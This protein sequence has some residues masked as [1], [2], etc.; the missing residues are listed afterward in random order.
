MFAICDLCKKHI[1]ISEPANIHIGHLCPECLAKIKTLNAS[2]NLHGSY[3]DDALN[4]SNFDFIDAFSKDESDYIDIYDYET[5]SSTTTD[6]PFTSEILNPHQIK[7]ELDKH[8]I[9]QERAKKVIA[10]GIYN[11]YKRISTQNSTIQKSNI[12]LVGP[13]GC[14]KTELARSVAKILNVPFAIADAT[15]VTEAGYVGD[16]VENILR[17]LISA[18]DNDVKK[19]EMGIVYIDEIDKLCRKSES[20]SITRDVSGEG[21]QQALL[22]ILE[23]SD[24]DVPMQGGR[25]HPLEKNTT[26]NTNN[27]LFICGGAFES[28]TM[29]RP[30]VVNTIGFS[31]HEFASSTP[32]PVVD[33]K[34]II[35]QG[36][37]PELVGR[38]PVIV[39]LDELLPHDL[40]RILVEPENS[41]VSQYKE[42]LKMD[43]ISLE[44]SKEALEYIANVAYN[45]NTGARGLKSVIEDFMID[46]MFDAPVYSTT[47]NILID[48][49]DTGLHYSYVDTVAC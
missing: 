45:N 33:S 36:L 22:K 25:K 49:T 18:A 4:I 3:S 39:K 8:I 23:G 42:L 21:V 35:K 26:I 31:S 34:A 17:K 27:I 13:S 12:L 30:S 38:L 16:D 41:I 20:T 48:V 19:A 15:T 2:N 7:A 9:G 14:G 47:R 37:I 24:V 40:V 5:S 6:A 43:G 32:E 28:L 46:L 1:P 10:V 44:F 29:K 11:H